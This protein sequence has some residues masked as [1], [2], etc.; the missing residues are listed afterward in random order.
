MKHSF[1]YLFGMLCLTSLGYAHDRYILPSHTVLS[2]DDQK[3]VTL[4]ASISNDMFHPQMPLGSNDKGKASP[5]LEALFQHM[6]AIVVQP[7][8]EVRP[9]SWQAFAMESV[10]DV[11]LSEAGTYRIAMVQP[12]TLMTTFKNADGSGSR[13]FG[14]NPQ[15][16]ADASDVV[17]RTIASRTESYLTLNRTSKKALAPTGQGL[18]ISWLSHPNDLFANEKVSFVMLFDGAPV[19]EGLEVSLVR[20]GTRHR[21]QR[22][23]MVGKTMSDGK[24]TVTFS[25]PGFYHLQA[26]LTQAGAAGSEIVKH[27]NSLYVTLEVFPE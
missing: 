24:C 2:G 13:R 18:E 12:A 26:S 6:Q 1:F 23:P 9:V 11:D 4:R 14:P 22:N 16:P 21:N 3:Q 20:G 8:G 15:I 17:K 25:E 7:D 10:A 19:A 27:H 5:T